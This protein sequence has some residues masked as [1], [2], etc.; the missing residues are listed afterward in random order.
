MCDIFNNALLLCFIIMFYSFS[1]M[2]DHK[3]EKMNTT[4]RTR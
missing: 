4:S 3:N 1:Y 2:K